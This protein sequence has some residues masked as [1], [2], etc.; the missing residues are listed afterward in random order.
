MSGT[1]TKN[2]RTI[3][4]VRA[5]TDLLLASLN[6]KKHKAKA[7]TI[8]IPVSFKRVARNANVNPRKYTLNL[9]SVIYS[10]KK[11]TLKITNRV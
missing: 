2:R 8:D 4:N 9:F 5:I 10:K 11:K 6:K 3:G 1:K 7:S